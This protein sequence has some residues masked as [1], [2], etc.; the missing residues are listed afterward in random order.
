[1]QREDYEAISKIIEDVIGKDTIGC[2]KILEGV[3]F[4]LDNKAEKVRV[5]ETPYKYGTHFN[6]VNS[7][8]YSKGAEAAMS[9]YNKK[10]REEG[11]K[12]KKKNCK[13]NS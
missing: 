8:Y 1:M 7:E 5:V 12:Y 4:Y 2:I 3:K 13:V 11:A 10:L 9:K 6:A